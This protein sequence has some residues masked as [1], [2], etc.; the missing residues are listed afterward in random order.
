MRKG[1]VGV[2]IGGESASGSIL[3]GLANY[4]C[5]AHFHILLGGR[6]RRYAD[7]HSRLTL[8][9]RATAPARSVPL[10]RFDDTAVGFGIAEGEPA[11]G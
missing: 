9:D 1:G 11:P 6:P 8:P 3:S 5:Q 7:T 10:N 2:C 4:R